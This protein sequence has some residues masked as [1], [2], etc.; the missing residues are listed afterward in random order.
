VTLDKDADFTR[1]YIVV[2]VELV[3]TIII[4]YAFTRV[5]AA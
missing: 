5:F 2:I 3:V 1:L 4:L